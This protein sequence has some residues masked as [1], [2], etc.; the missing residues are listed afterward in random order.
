MAADSG[1]DTGLHFYLTSAFDTVDHP[2]FISQFRKLFGIS[3]AS[4]LN[5]LKGL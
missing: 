1:N 3:D 4:L 5:Y 2:V